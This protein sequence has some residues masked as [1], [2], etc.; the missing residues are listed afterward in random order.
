MEDQDEAARRDAK[1]RM[2]A[3]KEAVR[4]KRAA[5]AEQA[6]TA[7]AKAE[8]SAPAA[9]TLVDAACR[10]GT[11]VPDREA[12]SQPPQLV[13]VPEPAPQE[14]HAPAAA[15]GGVDSAA[16]RAKE[17]QL[18]Q[19]LEG[20]Q[21]AEKE[22][23][24][25]KEMMA[26]QAEGIGTMQD[27]LGK[28]HAQLAAARSENAD[29]TARLPVADA[30]QLR[31]LRRRTRAL[32]AELSSS[33]ELMQQLINETAAGLAASAAGAARLKVEVAR[34][35]QKLASLEVA[36]ESL[37]EQLTSERVGRQKAQATANA[38]EQR[39]AAADERVARETQQLRDEA[40]EAIA[41]RDAL[42]KASKTRNARFAKVQLAHAQKLEA[43]EAELNSARLA[44]SQANQKLEQEVGRLTRHVSALEATLQDSEA[45]AVE[46]AEAAA[47]SQADASAA[48]AREQEMR[49]SLGVMQEE[50]R[51]ATTR[52]KEAEACS[53]RW[54][55]R[56]EAAEAAIAAADE[57]R[58]AATQS[59]AQEVEAAGGAIEALI[60]ERDAAKA[61]AA[62]L[63]EQI[64]ALVGRQGRLV[65]EMMAQE[66]K[67][68]RLLGDGAVDRRQV[69]NALV[70]FFQVDNTS[71]R[72]DRSLVG[73]LPHL[74]R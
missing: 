65:E 14:P 61:N 5:A 27:E 60:A 63:T 11:D 31:S 34:S 24:S 70:A 37:R 53:T 56:A 48:K 49:E 35:G 9:K 64:D 52:A 3:R 28:L 42:E 46:A 39:A 8:R 38:A 62:S 13:M 69:A 1:A 12:D 15:V 29:A 72:F 57:A 32:A 25:L 4:L 23:N 50:A 33:K 40:E 41:D 7:A 44:G 68:Q 43:L 6:A 17:Q 21:A 66:E 18:Q 45:S 20:Q 47:D 59:A 55:A 2:A 36:S 74:V 51:Q 26:L 73:F 58:V 19:A 54:Q 10:E 30:K 22:A 71:V 16:L 67:L